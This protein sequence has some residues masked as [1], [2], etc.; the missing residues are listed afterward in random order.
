MKYQQILS[1]IFNL[2]QEKQIFMESREN[3]RMQIESLEK[4][5]NILHQKKHN[6]SKEL[7]N[8]GNHIIKKQD[9]MDGII[10]G[11]IEKYPSLISL[12]P[13]RNPLADKKVK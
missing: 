3:C 6:L 5:I 8:I 9:A 1:K 7:S 12:K 4:D 10:I 13:K 11:F 2:F